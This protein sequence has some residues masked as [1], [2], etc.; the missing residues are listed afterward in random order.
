MSQYMPYNPFDKPIGTLTAD[1]LRL[2]VER[3]VAE[4]YFVEYKSDFPSN[5]KVARS[6]ASFANAYGGWYIIGVKANRQNQAQEICGF[7]LKITPDAISKVRDIVKSHTSPIPLFHQH[8]VKLSDRRAVLL[9]YVPGDQDTPFITNDG[10]IY[11]R[12]NDSSDPIAENDRHTIDKLVEAGRRADEEF[13]AFCRDDRTF[14]NSEDG[15]AWLRI[16]LSPYPRRVITKTDIILNADLQT[17]LER[18]KSPIDI[19]GKETTWFRSTIPFNV[20]Q[21]RF[22]SAVLRQVETSRLA[23]NSFETELF[24]DGSAKFLIPLTYFVG[25][26]LHT[27]T[28]ICSERIKSLFQIMAAD[29]PQKK[30]AHLRFLDV[31]RMWLVVAWCLGYYYDWI[32][33]DNRLFETR[34]AASLDGVWRSVPFFDSDEWAAQVEKS[35][36]PVMGRDA[37]SIPEPPGETLWLGETFNLRWLFFC[38]MIGFALGLPYE[39]SEDIIFQVV[40]R[41]AEEQNLHC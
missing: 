28:G 7:D 14:S 3:Q 41:T 31:A 25:V 2:L 38:H 23:F 29:D 12:N 32:G 39:I 35:G 33:S 21:P 26:G 40:R 17:R 6:V 18:T 24:V 11:R 34:I 37:V 22:R 27:P 9:V 4:G 13:A 8:I 10:R 20:A 19:V 5:Q 1:D 30:T 36:L 16:F 15:T